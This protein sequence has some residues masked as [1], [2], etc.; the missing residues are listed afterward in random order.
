MPLDYKHI[1]GIA[2]TFSSGSEYAFL[3]ANYAEIL[4]DVKYFLS[5]SNK[6]SDLEISKRFA[7]ASIVFTAFYVESLANLVIHRIIAKFGANS[8]FDQFINRK[9]DWPKPLRILFAAHIM[10]KK[11]KILSNT[12]KQW[13]CD[14]NAVK[15]LFLIRNQVLA[16]PPAHSTVAGTG[17][18]SG[19][20]LTQRGKHLSYKKFKC[21][22]NIYTEFTS[23]H[24]K[25]IYDDTTKF[26]KE[27]A[28]LLEST[29]EG[30]DLAGMFK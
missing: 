15:D 13:P 2:M 16:H 3:R 23:V 14:T 29:V 11:G 20:G 27:Y 30:K 18:V 26:L 21:F 7:R 8:D 10:L 9:D 28:K 24:A 25:D 6:A 22:P 12:K 19:I 1:G 5:E 17:V 4:K